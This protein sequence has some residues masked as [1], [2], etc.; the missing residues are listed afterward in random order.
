MCNFC[1]LCAGK[2]VTLMRTFNVVKKLVRWI[3]VC[4]AV[5]SMIILV[6]IISTRSNTINKLSDDSKITEIVK[7]VVLSL[8]GLQILFSLILHEG[9]RKEILWMIKA[10]L[11]F[12]LIKL[13]I[14]VVSLTRYISISR[15]QIKNGEINWW[16]F[17][18]IAA[19]LYGFLEAIVILIFHH[20]VQTEQAPPHEKDSTLPEHSNEDLPESVPLNDLNVVVMN[21]ENSS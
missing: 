3:A 10:W 7:L 14:Q 17:I 13:F 6:V 1:P 5:A 9:A 4:D 2:C 19:T 21:I 8:F 15:D 18:N 11:V 16:R 12:C 20:H